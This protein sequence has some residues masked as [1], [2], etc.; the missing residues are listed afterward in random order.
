MNAMRHA[1]W[2]SD[3]IDVV[4]LEPPPRPEGWAR[5]SVTGCGICGSDLHLYRGMRDGTLSPA[6]FSVPGHEVAGTVLDGPP[7]LDDALY[8]VEPWFSCRSCD[9]CL[10]GATTV[11]EDATL[12]GISG[13]GGLAD[14]VDIPARLLHR[15]PDTVDPAA[16]SMAEPWAVAVRALH[17]AGNIEVGERVLVLGGGTIGLLCGVAVRDR[18][19]DVG[20]TCRYPHQAELARS[21]GLTPIAPDELGAWAGEHRPGVVIETVGGEADTMSEA[22]RSARPG[23]R[24]VVVGVFGPRQP[25]DYRAVVLKELEVVG[26]IYYGTVGT[27]SEFGAAVATIGG[28]A[29]ELA[30]Q[31]TH[32]FGLDDAARAFTTADDKS[33]LAVKVTITPGATPEALV[34]DR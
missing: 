24:I 21:F 12:F 34:R 2:T 17:R 13:A 6:D 8:A 3:G 30:A 9:A 15:V 4:E 18:A 23:G 26:S 22:V 32:R 33:S 29:R 10:Q 27:G 25:T 11:C 20:V 31:Q 5:L 16:A 19:T 7:G 28:V 1:T 14:V